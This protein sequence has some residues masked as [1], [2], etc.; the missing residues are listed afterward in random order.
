M[1]PPVSRVLVV[2]SHMD[3]EVI[4][5]GGTIARH[6][7]K[8]DFVTVCVV[9]NRAYGHQYNGEE[10]KE[11]I[12]DC[13][14]AQK[15][16]GYQKFLYLGQKDECLDHSLIT[17]ITDLENAVADTEP[18]VV[19][20]PW[21]GDFNQDHRAVFGASMV[22]CRPYAPHRVDTLIAYESTSAS[23]F[24]NPFIPSLYVDIGLYIEKKIQALKCYRREAREWP[25]PRS[26]EGIMVLAKRRGSE[27]GLEE[28]ESF[29]VIREI[30]R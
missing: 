5:C 10:I 21:C 3:D 19:Y 29:M 12:D 27:I 2:A 22:V 17:V 11:E 1:S 23:Q 25:H 15:V 13:L 30:S 16:L 24:Y 9:A 8:G 28:A 26:P 14:S 4:S 7:E 18:T 6:V 20:I